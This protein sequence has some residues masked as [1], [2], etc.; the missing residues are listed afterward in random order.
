[1]L[2][3]LIGLDL[4][5]EVLD[6]IEENTLFESAMEAEEYSESIMDGSYDSYDDMDYDVDFE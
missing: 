3:M 2:E 1:M 6:Q 5:I 4:A